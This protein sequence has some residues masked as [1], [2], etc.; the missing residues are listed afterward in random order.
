MHERYMDLRGTSTQILS[1]VIMSDP[2]IVVPYDSSWK[3]E[4]KSI[5]LEIRQALGEL[6]I[7]IDHIGSTSI[8]GLDAKPII[9][10]QISIRSFEP[11]KIYKTK[12]ENIGYVYRYDNPDLTKRYFREKP[13]RKRIHIHIREFGSWSEQCSLLFRDYLRTNKD[14]CRKYA[15]VKYDLMKQYR[16]ERDRYVEGKEPIIW[17]IMSRASKWSQVTGWKP[18]K[19]DM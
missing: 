5:G 2:I 8:E 18:G 7:R 12:L 4:F 11:I 13:G 17:E 9:D 19:T 14:D 1:E 3:E 10:I 15:V 16:N 6:A